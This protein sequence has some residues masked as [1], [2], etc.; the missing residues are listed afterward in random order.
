MGFRLLLGIAIS[1]FFGW[2]AQAQQS[3]LGLDQLLRDPHQMWSG[4]FKCGQGLRVD[5]EIFAR[6]VSVDGRLGLFLMNQHSNRTTA[7]FTRTH[8]VGQRESD[9]SYF[10][11]ISSRPPGSGSPISSAKLKSF[12][13]SAASDSGLLLTPNETRCQPVQ[14]KLRSQLGHHRSALLPLTTGTYFQ[15]STIPEVCKVLIDWAA[16]YSGE[17]Y[18][19]PAEEAAKLFYDEHFIPVFGSPYDALTGSQKKAIMDR[20]S[21]GRACKKDPIMSAR[22]GRI[23]ELY[24]FRWFDEDEPVLLQV[25]K[26]FK[27]RSYAAYMAKEVQNNRLAWKEVQNTAQRA[28]QI[29]AKK[30]VFSVLKELEEVLDTNRSYLSDDKFKATKTWI[31]SA[32]AHA[33][34]VL[35]RSEQASIFQ[36]GNSPDERLASL[37]A[38][39]KALPGY[40]NYLDQKTQKNLEAARDTKALELSEAIVT[41]I[42]QAALALPATVSGTTELDEL[43]SS[44]LESRA[45]LEQSVR[46]KAVKQLESERDRNLGHLI[47]DEVSLLSSIGS[48]TQGLRA[49]HKW[50]LDFEGKFKAFADTPQYDEALATYWQSREAL[51][52]GLLPV[53]EERVA[54]A[55]TNSQIDKLYELYL[56]TEPDRS[57]LISLEYEFIAENAKE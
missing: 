43:I 51:L 44:K 13:L 14:L 24:M 50:R 2:S 48:D 38:F 49:G 52:E 12:S 15:A 57:L 31:N 55:K 11:A 40:Y 8:F 28:T 33:A 19:V 36:S 4:Q 42:V 16:S 6:P 20:I 41:P 47:A 56:P 34:T 23:D 45:D 21:K 30:E 46:D 29:G 18:G 27:N 22:F 54:A 3:S 1:C 17:R 32:R 5:S 7:W 39:G 37:I 10:F 9:G 35:A 26:R 53:F 25:G